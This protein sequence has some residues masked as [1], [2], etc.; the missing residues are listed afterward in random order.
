MESKKQYAVILKGI[1]GFY[2]V[3]AEGETIECK[4]G[5]RLRK[6]RDFRPAVGDLAQIERHG[7][8]GYIV[9]IEQRRNFLLRP[10]IANIDRL[11]IVASQADPI[12]DSYLIDK[13]MVIAQYQKIEPILLLNKWDLLPSLQMEADY[14]GAGIRVLRTSAESGQG[15]DELRALLKGKI[16]AFTGNSGIGKSSLLNRLELKCGADM[17]T[18]GISRISRGRHTTRHV[19]L[20][21]VEGGGYLADTPGFSSFDISKMEHIPKEELQE[22]YEEFSPYLG[23]CRYHGCAHCKEPGCAVEEAAQKGEISRARLENY[24]KLYEELSQW[25]EWANK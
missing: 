23:Q 4:A 24:R 11:F 7:E 10:P 22:Y 13:V 2:Y 17:E 16:S 14:R 21:P 6:L 18:G 15:I 8:T 12:T 3:D 1:G 19:E 25:K 5:G 9:S 20:F